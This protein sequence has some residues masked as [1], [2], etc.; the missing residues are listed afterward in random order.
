MACI[1][2]AFSRN[3]ISFFAAGFVV[4]AKKVEKS[5]YNTYCY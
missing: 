4:E 1:L 2:L 3:I 5:K